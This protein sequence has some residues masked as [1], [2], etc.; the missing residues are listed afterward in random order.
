MPVDFNSAIQQFEAGRHAEAAETC[1]SILHHNPGDLS[2]SNMLGVIAASRGNFAEAVECFRAC[3]QAAPYDVGVVTNFAQS[4]L[5]I[6]ELKEALSQFRRAVRLEGRD[7]SHLAVLENTDI[8]P[9]RSKTGEPYVATLTDVR[10][11]TGYW[12]IVKDQEIYFRETAN[13]NPRNSPLTK[14]RVSHNQKAVVVDL[15]PT[16]QEIETP[17]IFLG[18]DENYA[19][20]LT[21][22]LMRLALVEN[23][24]TFAELPLLTVEDLKPFQLD[25]LALLGI[26][27]DRLIKIPRHSMIRVTE[28]VVPTCLRLDGRSIEVGTR[29]LRQKFL[30]EESVSPPAPRS[31][32]FISRRDA[33]SRYM[34]N[35]EEISRA[36]SKL[37]FQTL[38]LSEYSFR[39]Q[40]R[41]FSNAEIVVAPHG[42]G[43]ANMIFAPKD[44]VLFEIV[45]EPIANM[46]EFRVIAQVL[47]QSVTTVNCQSFEIHPGATNPAAQHDFTLDAAALMETVERNLRP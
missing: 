32:L 16:A 28:I 38:K 13:L 8:D 7:D 24:C 31:R 1:R 34:T 33:P 27:D 30:S 20:W 44:C 45:S 46:N 47:G 42:A 40:I 19:H 2:A 41:M 36:L 37:G 43:L 22:Y 25:S 3:A 4:L 5:E 29:W 21:R 26:N 35:E 14:G 18:G 11:D 15:P 12:G 10:I 39:D 6:G 17:C 23:E 9:T